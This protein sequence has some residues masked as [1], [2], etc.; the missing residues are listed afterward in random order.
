M[1]PG[2][3]YQM[4]F[5][6]YA[7][8]PALNGS[9]LLHLRRSPMKYKHELDNPTPPSPAMILGTATHRLILEPDRVGDFAVWGL[10]EEEKVRRGKVWDHFQEFNAG[11]MI[12]TVAERDAMVGMAVGARRNLP[13]MKYANAKGKTEVSMFW[14]AGGRDFKGRVDKILDQGHVIF[15]LKTTRDCHPRRFGAQSYALG[16]HIKMALYSNGYYAITGELPKMHLGAI[17]SKA[18]HESAV[19][20]VTKD[21]IL[22]GQDELIDLLRTLAECEAT[23]NWSAAYQEETDLMIPAWALTE[24]DSLA[25]FAE[26]TEEV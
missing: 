20:R 15:D 22:Q 17:D 3:Y 24:Q 6:E 10:L 16:Y 23:N 9:S 2:F 25:E 19:Y 5:E 21:V 8:V 12:V 18:P 4:P 11:A 13:I 26:E 7:A 14:T 1:K